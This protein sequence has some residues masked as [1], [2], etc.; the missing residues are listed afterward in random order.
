MRKRSLQN[1][2]I[3]NRSAK[4]AMQVMQLIHGKD[5][6]QMRPRG[7]YFEHGVQ[8]LL[9]AHTYIRNNR[10]Y[11]KSRIPQMRESLG[12]RP[13]REHA[14]PIGFEA[15]DQRLMGLRILAN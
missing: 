4:F 10:R 2:K 1:M 9:T 5:Q 6:W 8:V 13:Y 7:A 12:Q 14:V 15:L 11:S 3:A